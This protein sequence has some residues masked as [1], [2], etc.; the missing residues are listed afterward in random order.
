MNEMDTYDNKIPYFWLLFARQ[1]FQVTLTFTMTLTFVPRTLQCSLPITTT[2]N[3]DKMRSLLEWS[4]F[5]DVFDTW[6]EGPLVVIRRG[7]IQMR[8]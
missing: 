7:V 4:L 1:K 8:L 6:N 2:K 3:A 5:R